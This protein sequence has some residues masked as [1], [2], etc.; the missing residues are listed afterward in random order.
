MLEFNTIGEVSKRIRFV[1]P[2][3]SFQGFK[4]QGLQDIIFCICYAFGKCSSLVNEFAVDT[5]KSHNDGAP[6]RRL[7]VSVC[8]D[9]TADSRNSV[10]RNESFDTGIEIIRSN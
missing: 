9:V 8:D 1:T 2:E 7:R 6:D 5:L 10:I 4:S 3:K